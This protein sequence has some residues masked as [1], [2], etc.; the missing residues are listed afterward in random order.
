MS[1]IKVIDRHLS[2]EISGKSALVGLWLLVVYLFL[3][4]LDQLE[5]GGEQQISSVMTTLGYAIPRMIYELSP[6]IILIGTILAMTVLS[7]Q[8]E[9]IA[10]QASGVSKARIVGSVVGFSA[11]FALGIFLWGELVVP[12]SETKGSEIGMVD[13][14]GANVG[15][16]GVWFRHENSFIFIDRMDKAQ[17]VEDVHVYVFDERGNLT[18]LIEAKTG[19]IADDMDSLA[20]RTVEE[21]EF[22]DTLL[23]KDSVWAKDLPIQLDTLTAVL[24]RDNPAELNIFELYRLVQQRKAIGL[25]SDFDELALWNRL[26]IPLSMLVMGMFAVLFTFRLKVRLSTGHFVMFGLLFGLF[27]FAVQQSVGYIAI[28]NG[29]API[30][31]MLAAFIVFSSYALIAL[32]RL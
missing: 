11:A 7:R 12:F 1:A 19:R 18:E 21:I 26:I 31:G 13:Q 3:S 16:E 14:T 25:K 5:G 4:L 32:Y 2:R 9:L 28:L 15:G 6:M 29:I 10:L 27:Y 22:R 30:F 23:V 8:H 20:L 17:R 24:Q